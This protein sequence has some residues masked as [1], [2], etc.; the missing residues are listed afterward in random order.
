MTLNTIVNLGLLII[1]VLLFLN[2]RNWLKKHDEKIDRTLERLD[3]ALE[4]LKGKHA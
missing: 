2:E 1:I 4:K 3:Q